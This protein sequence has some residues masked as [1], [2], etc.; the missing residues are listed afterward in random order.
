MYQRKCWRVRL[1]TGGINWARKDLGVRCVW[2]ITMATAGD[3]VSLC[4]L[5]CV[6]V[7]TAPSPLPDRDPAN[8]K[9]EKQNLHRRRVR[10]SRACAGCFLWELNPVAWFRR[11]REHAKGQTGTADSHGEGRGR[12]IQLHSLFSLF[13]PPGG[14]FAL[15]CLSLHEVAP[16]FCRCEQWPC[17]Q[18]RSRAAESRECPLAC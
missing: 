4:V 5:V 9:P 16:F 12:R 17:T 7:I 18:P 3:S 2:R 8:L 1:D 14:L 6:G 15:S 10:R 13:I 11:A